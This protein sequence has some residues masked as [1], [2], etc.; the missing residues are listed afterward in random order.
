MNQKVLGI[1]AGVFITLAVLGS[2]AFVY[3]Q[4]SNQETNTNSEASDFWQKKIELRE[5]VRSGIFFI[6]SSY[7]EK[8]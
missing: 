7:L 4:T 8:L 3:A 5:K 2:L 1:I 6:F